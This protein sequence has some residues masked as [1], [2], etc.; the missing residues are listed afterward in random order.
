MRGR[1]S[2][3][4]ATFPSTP[5]GEERSDG[6]PQDDCSGEGQDEFAKQVTRAVSPI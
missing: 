3:G 2:L 5:P 1:A 4:A 6:C